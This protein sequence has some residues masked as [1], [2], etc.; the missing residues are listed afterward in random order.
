[1]KMNFFFFYLFPQ[2]FNGIVIGRLRRQI[3]DRKAVGFLF[4]K[5]PHGPTGDLPVSEV[6]T[7]FIH[8]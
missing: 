3:V 5:K 7:T 8:F 4:I 6:L 2:F 1:M